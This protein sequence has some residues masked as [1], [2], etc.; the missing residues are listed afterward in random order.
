M[1]SAMGAYGLSASRSAVV[2]LGYPL[3][4]EVGYGAVGIPVGVTRWPKMVSPYVPDHPVGGR[5]RD[6]Q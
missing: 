4:V 3:H 2:P 5:V 1:K 6:M